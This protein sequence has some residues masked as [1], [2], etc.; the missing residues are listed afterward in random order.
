M[1]T[2]KQE[3]RSLRAQAGDYIKQDVS[4]LFTANV[5]STVIIV[6]CVLLLLL[7]FAV[8]AVFAQ[9]TSA[10]SDMS[11]GEGGAGNDL[12]GL[13]MAA[14][15]S[16]FA[17]EDLD[18]AWQSFDD[19]YQTDPEFIQ[20][21]IARSY[22]SLA[23]GDIETALEDAL[24]ALRANPE[25]PSIDYLLGSIYFAHGEYTQSSRHFEHYLQRV[26][27]SRDAPTLMKRL[28]DEN[29]LG[30]ANAYL[31]ACAARLTEIDW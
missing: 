13:Y 15:M 14:G 4:S 5:L 17:Q 9:D 19:S 28:T 2:Q 8:P 25:D 27:E 22:V 24:F 11:G 29:S 18:V 6:L 30:L 31:G 3:P 23:Q 16:A 21:L 20:A 7:F 1:S 26:E 12:A 10:F